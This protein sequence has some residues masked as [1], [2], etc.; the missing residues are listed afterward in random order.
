MLP[1]PVCAGSDPGRSQTDCRG[2]VAAGRSIDCDR[3]EA[4]RGECPTRRGCTQILGRAQLRLVCRDGRVERSRLCRHP[5]EPAAW[6]PGTESH[7]ARVRAIERGS[8]GE[9]C[10]RNRRSGRAELPL[11]QNRAPQTGAH[12]LGGEHR[13]VFGRGGVRV[14]ESVGAGPLRSRAL[15]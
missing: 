14:G 12:G 13:S 5:I 4:G 7:G 3:G 1:R 8:G 10:R 6:R 9:L 15:G 11:P 2:S